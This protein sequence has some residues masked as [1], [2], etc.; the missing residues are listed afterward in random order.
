MSLRPVSPCCGKY[1]AAK[2]GTITLVCEKCNCE[3]QLL[4]ISTERM[5]KWK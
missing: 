3:F 2:I 5:E 1:L 4:R